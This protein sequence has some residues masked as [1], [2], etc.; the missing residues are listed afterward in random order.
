MEELRIVVKRNGDKVPYQTKKIYAAIAGAN[1]D[2][3]EEMSAHA[4]SNAVMQTDVKLQGKREISV[5]HIQ[6]MVEETLMDNKYF[7]TA[8]QFI[9]YR[10][11]H[12][13]RREANKKLMASY[14]DLLFTDAEDMDLKRDNANINTDAPMGIMLKLGTEGAKSWALSYGLPEK[15]VKAHKE[16]AIHYHDLDFSFITLNCLQQDLGKTLKGGFN[17][18]HGFLRE[19]NSI[20]A[21]ASLACI[22]IQSSQN[23]CFGGQS[24][25][26]L[27]YALA[28]YVEKSFKKAYRKALKEAFFNYS[29][30][31]P[32][33]CRQEY[34]DAAIAL[35]D[36]TPDEELGSYN[37]PQGNWPEINNFFQKCLHTDC[38][39]KNPRTTA[40]VKFLIHAYEKACNDVEE[41]TKQAM[42]A[43]IHNFNSLHSR[44]GS[45][46]P[47]SSINF[48]M[49]TTPEGR[50]VI[51]KTLDAIDAGLGHGETP[52]FPISVFTL[53]AG[54]NYN[55]GDPN[56]DLFQRACEVSAK[57]LYPNFTNLDAPMNL[58]YYKPD[59]YNSFFA[60][61]G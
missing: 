29:V 24:I 34:I 26:A 55:P 39:D 41:E 21:A 33:A 60:C 9:I 57:R 52:I 32:R 8:K 51:A 4:I 54:V 5:E 13:K 48:G 49:N 2:S 23:D 7:K 25:N 36:K 43:M 59:D 35:L 45:Q 46:V 3:H 16:H 10:D 22:A 58:K 31:M 37:G 11:L 38:V 14:S 20:R 44:A 56:Y 15:F 28:P 40:A 50:L 1:K 27:D 12:N 42:E 53:K 18:G 17:P 61:M 19:P 30:A 47:F 6:D